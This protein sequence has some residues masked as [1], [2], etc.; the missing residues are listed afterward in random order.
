M[1]I[2]PAIIVAKEGLD[3]KSRLCGAATVYSTRKNINAAKRVEENTGTRCIGADSADE[4]DFLL[5][6]SISL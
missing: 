4:L 3:L 6:L 1:P 2:C 5:K